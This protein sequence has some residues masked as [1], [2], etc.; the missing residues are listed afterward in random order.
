MRRQSNIIARGKRNSILHGQNFRLFLLCRR[1]GPS[2][3][4]LSGIFFQSAGCF[5]NPAEF[6]SVADGI[7]ICIDVHEVPAE[8]ATE[9]LGQ[10]LECD[11]AVIGLLL[12]SQG[13]DACDLIKILWRGVA[14]PG[15][16]G[17]C[18]GGS[19]VAK[20]SQQ[21]AASGPGRH[22]FWVASNIHIQ[23]TEGI[24]PSIQFLRQ[25]IGLVLE[26]IDGIRKFNRAFPLATQLT[27]SD[28]SSCK[29]FSRSRIAPSRSPAS[30]RSSERMK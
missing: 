6:R 4:A 3:L 8:T 5:E 17:V 10:Q 23:N 22:R 24:F 28:G 9:R 1:L 14:M 7:E 15:F 27:A 12:G 20:S 19:H 18:S 21:H 29:P 26:R 13:I 30:Q 2:F 25:D 11:D 16:F